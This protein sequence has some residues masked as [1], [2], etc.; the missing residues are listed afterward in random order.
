MPDGLLKILR[1]LKSLEHEYLPATAG[2]LLKTEKNVQA[3][4]VSGMEYVFL[5]VES[6]L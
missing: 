6:G 3:Q 5:G 1:S 2:T 4:M